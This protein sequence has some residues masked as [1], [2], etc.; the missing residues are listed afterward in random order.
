MKAQARVSGALQRSAKPDKQSQDEFIYGKRSRNEQ[1]EEKKKSRKNAPN[2][3]MKV[4][5]VAFWK[6]K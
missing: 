4:L 5:K 6:T 2:W 3:L 1:R